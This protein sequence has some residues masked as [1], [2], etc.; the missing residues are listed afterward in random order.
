MIE[1]GVDQV[2]LKHIDEHFGGQGPRVNV[3]ALLLQAR[4]FN[5]EGR[6]SR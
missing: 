4:R 3:S 1:P 2:I 6:K 5:A